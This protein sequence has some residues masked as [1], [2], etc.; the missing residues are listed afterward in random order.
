MTVLPGVL[1]ALR[2]RA[3]R[4]FTIGNV[5]SL[6]GQW[7]QRTAL[8]WLMWR[9]THSGTW[10]GAL[11]F[12]ELAPMVLLSPLTGVLADRWRYLRVMRAVQLLLAGQALTPG[13]ML[14]LVG[15]G[16]I[17]T[18]VDNP[19]RLSL[20]PT[21]VPRPRLADALALNSMLFNLA[22]FAGPMLAAALLASGGAAL[23][24][25]ANALAALLFCAALH[26]LREPPLARPPTPEPSGRMFRDG[27]RYAF[28]HPGLRLMM[29]ISVAAALLARS[30]PEIL[31]GYAAL[32]GHEAELFARMSAVVG[33]GAM[34]GGILVARG[35]SPR[36]LA[37]MALTAA[38]ALA[39]V[40]ILLALAPGR[41]PAL[42]LL[43]LLGTALVVSAV[44]NLSVIQ[45]TADPSRRG[46]VLSLHT[47]IFRGGPAAGALAIGGLSD[48]VGL[49][50]VL[51]L[52][53]GLCLIL[54]L[55]C[56]SRR[57]PGLASLL[58]EP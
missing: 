44:S 6:L 24:F 56:A 28:S 58:D 9:M 40:V 31:P 5:P 25:V 36:R 54:A 42:A 30:V 11:A 43:F 49:R 55:W 46:R 50:L 15:L 16:G 38:G 12:V 20:V 29:G 33:A 35:R 47:M 45:M 37:L 3:Y 27:L 7:A 1:G 41:V 26:L 19:F 23:A 53:G 48:L 34:L 8:A 4:H 51:A 52:S 39:C 17:A 57:Q 10:I 22:R 13:L 21:L 2:C 18:A 32:F 14:V